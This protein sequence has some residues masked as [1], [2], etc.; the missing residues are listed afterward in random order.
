MNRRVGKQPTRLFVFVH[1]HRSGRLAESLQHI[2]DASRCWRGSKSLLLLGR[3][4]LVR[5]R[6]WEVGRMNAVRAVLIASTI[7]LLA[8]SPLLVPSFG[9]SLG[10]GQTA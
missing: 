3:L 1:S 4:C 7:F 6:T 10:T 5:T 8:A 2:C 9:N